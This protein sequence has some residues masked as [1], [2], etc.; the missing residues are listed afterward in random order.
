MCDS[1]HTQLQLIY[2]ENNAVSISKLH[3]NSGFPGDRLEIVNFR[4]S[5]LMC[6][7]FKI[8]EYLEY[9]LVRN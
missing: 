2:E 7:L 9:S 5:Q 4:P 8:T 6:Q 1:G 3:N